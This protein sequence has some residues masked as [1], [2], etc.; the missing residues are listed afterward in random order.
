MTSL[1]AVDVGNSATKVG[2]FREHALEFDETIPTRDCSERNVKRTLVRALRCLE[3]AERGRPEVALC[4][5]VPAAATVWRKAVREAKAR[6]FVIQGDT[7]APLANRYRFPAELGPDRLAAAVAAAA[8]H[9]P[10]IVVSLGTATTIDAVSAK[11]EF[12]GGAICPGIAISLEALAIATAML[13]SVSPRK[14]LIAIGKDTQEC[15]LAGSYFGTIGQVNEIIRRQREIVGP[16]V[17]VVAGGY[18][19]MVAGEIE[20]GAAV[21]DHLTLEGIRLIWQHNKIP[22]RSRGRKAGGA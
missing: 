7:P 2:A 13:P 11:G 19:D 10:V 16:A 1:L 6:L 20:A 4:S 8:L 5:V 15:L 17:V 18:A 22:A 21:E 12:L 9:R 3:K 14:P